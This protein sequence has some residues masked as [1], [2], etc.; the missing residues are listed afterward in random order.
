MYYY[1][2]LKKCLLT[3]VIIASVYMLFPW[4]A[5][6]IFEGACVALVLMMSYGQF[7]IGFS[8]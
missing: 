2:N 4:A 7:G 5:H 6:Q 3:A 8:K 1:G